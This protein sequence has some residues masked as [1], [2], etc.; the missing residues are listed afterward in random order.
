M[1]TES[2][3]LLV[4]EDGDG[5]EEL[6]SS[7][8]SCP[9]C[10]FSFGEIEPRNFLFNAPFGACPECHGLGTEMEIDERLLVTLRTG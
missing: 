8:F 10:D 3:R 6:V 9:D 5:A 1:N 2:R 7:V 4:V